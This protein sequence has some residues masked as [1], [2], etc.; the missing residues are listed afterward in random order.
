MILTN[1][2][3]KWRHPDGT[4][5]GLRVTADMRAVNSVFVGDYF[6][7]EDVNGIVSWMETKR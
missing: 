1:F 3:N 7:T 4:S 5:A 6:P 2:R